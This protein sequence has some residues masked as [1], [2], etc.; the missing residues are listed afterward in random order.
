MTNAIIFDFD[1]VIA[2]SQHIHKKSLELVAREIGADFNEKSYLETLANPLAVTLKPYVNIGKLPSEMPTLI[3]IYKSYF[4][5]HLHDIKPI[6]GAENLIR[7]LKKNSFPSAIAS[8]SSFDY[9]TYSLE[10]F[11]FSDFFENR[12]ASIDMVEK[13]KPAPD[14][15]LLAAQK[16][17]IDPHNCLVIENASDGIK[18][19]ELA[20]MTPILFLQKSDATDPNIK[21]RVIHNLTDVTEIVGI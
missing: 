2:D 1:G 20:G 11:G 12:V 14:L 10:K 21:C 7:K 4:Y 15:F 19:A 17:S 16:L 9:V 6:Q 8:S 5:N 18:A 13:G 3:K